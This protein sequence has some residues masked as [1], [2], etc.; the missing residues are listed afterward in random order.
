[1]AVRYIDFNRGSDANS[2]STPALAWK[3][4]SA[5]FNFNPGAGGGLFLASDSVWDIAPTR[6][7]HNGLTQ[8]QFNGASGNPAFITAYDPVANTTGSMP[9]MANQATLPTLIGT[10][11][12]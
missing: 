6:A 8:T 10:S 3:N 12:M 5:G 9:T 2:G 11:A 4:L 1:M 7:A